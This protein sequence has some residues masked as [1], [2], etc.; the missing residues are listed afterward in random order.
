MR[1]TVLGTGGTIA[2]T[3]SDAGARPNRTGTDILDAVPGLDVNASLTVEDVVQL[4]SFE[5]TE[6]TLE[7]I[8][9]RV[10]ELDA[11]PSVDAVVITHGTD[12]MEETAY[13]L[14]AARR[15]ETPVFLTGAQRRPDETSPDGPANLRATFEAA[16]AFTDRDASG[17]FVVFDDEMHAA[18]AVTKTHTSKLDT[19]ASPTRG[20]VASVDHTGVH[21]HRP[22]RSETDAMDAT[23]LDASVAMVK[24]GVGV[25]ATLA[26]AAVDSGAEGLVL[27]GTGLGNATPDIASVVAD[28]ADEIPVVVTSRCHAGRT[29]PV[30]GANGGGE[31]L[32]EHG[33]AFAADLPTH[34]ARLKL[35]LALAANDTHDDVLAAFS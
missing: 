26:T 22:P 8:G 20:P 5:F 10:A 16:H 30:Y 13:Y 9:D 33:A 18:R 1:V 15:P 35:K 34:K 19:F 12:T 4:P 17:V 29:A 24:S 3:Q 31:R 23:S 28:V 27:E 21:V 7:T 6:G 25:D 14:D 32:R 2:S 11:D